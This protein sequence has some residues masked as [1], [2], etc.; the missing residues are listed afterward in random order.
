MPI[1]ITTNDSR[2]EISDDLSSMTISTIYTSNIYTAQPVDEFTIILRSYLNR[3]ISEDIFKNS[4]LNIC[5][6][7]NKSCGLILPFIL[8]QNQE[9]TLSPTNTNFSDWNMDEYTETRTISFSNVELELITK[10]SDILFDNY[11]S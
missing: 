7:S 9:L 2:T 4:M 6:K 8:S 5:R 3:E 1:I 11:L 10:T